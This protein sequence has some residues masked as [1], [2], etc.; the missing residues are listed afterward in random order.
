MESNEA[1]QDTTTSELPTKAPAGATKRPHKF[2]YNVMRDPNTAP[3][4]IYIGNVS[5]SVTEED[6]KNKFSKYG[7]II[8]M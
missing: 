5:E 2:K 1:S 4:R 7:Q 3:A 8:G 6:L